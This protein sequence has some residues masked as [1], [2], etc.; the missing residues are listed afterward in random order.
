MSTVLWAAGNWKLPRGPCNERARGKLVLRS[1]WTT[2]GLMSQQWQRAYTVRPVVNKTQSLPYFVAIQTKLLFSGCTELSSFPQEHVCAAHL[3]PLEEVPKQRNEP[4]HLG[5]RAGFPENYAECITKLERLK[6]TWWE[7]F[8][9]FLSRDSRESV[10]QKGSWF[11]DGRFALWSMGWAHFYATVQIR[12][13]D[14]LHFLLP[15]YFRPSSQCQPSKF[16]IEYLLEADPLVSSTKLW[17]M[18]AYAAIFWSN[19]ISF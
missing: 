7:G 8:H 13:N 17:F 4:S 19:T 6:Y 1:I 16:W 5:S 3:K 18:W 9:L 2:W 14:L 11:G 15:C 10:I 12:G